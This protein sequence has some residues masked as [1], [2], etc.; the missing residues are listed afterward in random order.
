MTLR[1]YVCLL[2]ILLPLCLHPL[3]TLYASIQR[4]GALEGKHCRWSTLCQREQA[5]NRRS[6]S[7]HDQGYH[8][9][10]RVLVVLF[11][12]TERRIL[13]LYLVSVG[14]AE[15]NSKYLSIAHPMIH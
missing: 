7:K 12:L 5:I 1:T 9:R 14:K 10:N 3:M 2:F 15:R 4:G 11:D 13:T 6:D 8:S